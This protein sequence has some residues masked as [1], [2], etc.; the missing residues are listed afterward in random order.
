MKKGKFKIENWLVETPNEIFHMRDIKMIGKKEK[1]KILLALA[2]ASI[3]LKCKNEK[4]RD[5]LYKWFSDALS[6]YV[7][8]SMSQ[9]K[10]YHQSMNKFMGDSLKLIKQSHA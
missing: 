5:G 3:D 10:D 7:E 8:S 6:K 1:E 9:S 4:E 2:F